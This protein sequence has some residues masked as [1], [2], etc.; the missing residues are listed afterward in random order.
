MLVKWTSFIKNNHLMIMR[1]NCLTW[2]QQNV[3]SALPVI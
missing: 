3:A 2:H 1:K